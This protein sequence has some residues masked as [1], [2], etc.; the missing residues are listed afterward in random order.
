MQCLYSTEDSVTSSD[1]WLH[2]W[3]TLFHRLVLTPTQHTLTELTLGCDE[4]LSASS[5]PSFAALHFPYLCALSLRNIMFDP[6]VES[7]IL[8]H[9]SALV[10]L[11]LTTCMLL[12]DIG[13]VGRQALGTRLGQLRSGSHCPSCPTCRRELR[14]QSE[15]PVCLPCLCRILLQD[16]G[17]R[18][19]R[20][21]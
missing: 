2:F 8:R 20:R 15:W 6:S 19:R 12:L 17:S 21:D 7:F 3:G 18:T 11:E 5:R 9:A 14:Q 16:A 10:H 4:A 13:A 1:R